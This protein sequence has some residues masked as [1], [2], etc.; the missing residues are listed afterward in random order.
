MIR[1]RFHLKHITTTVIF[2]VLFTGCGKEEIN[3]I[4]PPPPVANF[5]YEDFTDHASLRSTSTGEISEYLWY[6]SDD[7]QTLLKPRRNNA[8]LNLPSVATKVTVSL[9][10]KNSG[11]SS[12]YTEIIDLP[13][14]TFCRKYGLGK[15]VEVEHSNNVDYEWYIDQFD[16]GEY[17]YF[18]CGPSCVTMA[19]KWANQNFS[20]TTEEARYTLPILQPLPGWLWEFHEI[21]LSDN[22]AIWE[23]K[24]FRKAN[25]LKNQIDNGNILIIALRYSRI[26][27]EIKSD[28]RIDRF[29]PIPWGSIVDH[30]MIIKGYK[31]VDDILWFEA[32]DP[33][34]SGMRNIG[35]GS[36]KGRDRYYRDDDIIE[37]AFG[38]SQFPVMIVIYKEII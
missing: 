37:A 34:S 9:T 38:H 12:T 5:V 15:N 21:Y 30:Y 4:L 6:A 19:L 14:L 13:A 23:K 2:F 20:K 11:G 1:F 18:N 17:G 25:D 24:E 16:T 22:Q 33:A 26:R 28:W 36:L 35:D 31:I 3:T 32:Y 10:V 8:D 7:Y 29:H 27:E